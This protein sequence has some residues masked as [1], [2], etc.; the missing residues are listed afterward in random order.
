M[1]DNNYVDNAQLYKPKK[2]VAKNGDWLINTVNLLF[3]FDYF[4]NY[5]VLFCFFRSHPI[6]SFH[7]C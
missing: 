6:V 2:E 1:I 5:S 3:L 7:I 4:I